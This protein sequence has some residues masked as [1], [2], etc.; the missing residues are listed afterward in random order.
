MKY[1]IILLLTTLLVF[2][3]SCNEMDQYPHNAVSSDNLTEKDAQLLLTGLYFYMQ[4]KPTTNGYFTQDIVGGDLVRGGATGLKDPVLLVKDL[5]TPESGFV[6]GPWDGFYTALYQVN[7]LIVALDKLAANQSRNEMLGVACFFRG[8]I[9][10]NLVSRYGEVPI[11]KMPFSGD[12]AASTEEEGWNFVEENF[13]SA[14]D[15]APA[16][17][18]KHYVSKQAAKA[19]MARTKLARGKLTEAA[20]LAEE[21]INDVNFSLADFDQIFRGKANREEIFSFANLLKES[22]VNLGASLYSRA[23]SNGGSYMYAPTVKVM[24][25]F[26]PDDKRTSISINMQ[27]T[28]EVIN[29]YSGGEVAT[30][31]IIITRLGEMYLISAEAQGLTKGL[32]RLNELRN[33]RGLPSIH[34]TS[35]KDFLDAVLKERHMELL[36]EGFRWFDL[37]RLKRLESDLGFER[38]YNRLPIPAKEMALNKLLKQNSYWAN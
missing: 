26:E 25:M 21:V 24:N 23:S 19:L 34:P 10:Y 38:K 5:I 31:P 27:E 6:S 16:F 14:I 1:Y 7:S 37:V 15:Y 3:T 17:T 11:L 33:F 32:S 2:A 35:E 20:K 8:L 13:Q 18:D 36:A 28:N 29:K 9:Y 4:N 30:D 12:V 22:S